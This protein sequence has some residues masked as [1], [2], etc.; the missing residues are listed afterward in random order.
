MRESQ[1]SALASKLERAWENLNG[2]I[3]ANEIVI[4]S[5][6]ACPY[7]RIAIAAMREAGYEP[8]IVK[9][10]Y[11]QRQALAA[12]YGSTSVPKVFVKGHFVGGCNDGGMGGVLPMLENGKFAEL[13][14][15]E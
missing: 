2:A 12:R 6:H 13:S 3:Q 10:G 15:G 9:V 8:S 5:S 14:Q 11:T 7:C 4:F 1:Q